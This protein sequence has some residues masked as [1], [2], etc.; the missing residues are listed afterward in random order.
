MPR[1]VPD[2]YRWSTESQF[3][4]E[5]D[6]IFLTISHSSIATPIRIVGDTVNYFWRVDGDGNPLRWTGFTFDIALLS[7]DDSTPKAQLSVQNIDQQ[8][9]L[10]IA[11]LR[12]SPRLEI[13][14]LCSQDFDLNERP[15]IP[16][17]SAEPTVLYA[18]HA[19]WLVNVKVDDFQ[20]TGDIQ[21]W[22]YLQRA[23]PGPRATQDALPA[24]FR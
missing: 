16:K 23:W 17:A 11:N 24:L 2:S 10:A 19:L 13:Q 15:R 4:E 21:G 9:G 20:V 3:S 12:T 5:V 14:L 22:D 18:A 7:D 8:I 6:L 1:T